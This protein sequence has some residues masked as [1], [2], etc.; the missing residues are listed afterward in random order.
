[1]SGGLVENRIH[2][3]QITLS[4][5]GP[6]GQPEVSA[7]APLPAGSYDLVPWASVAVLPSDVE[8]TTEELEDSFVEQRGTSATV[9]GEPVT[10]VVTGEADAETGRTRDEAGVVPA[11]AVPEP[12]C[13]QPAPTVAGAG[14]LQVEVVSD[15][16][17]TLG[18]RYDGP[19][20]ARG[21]LAAGAWQIAVRDGVV[22]GSNHIPIDMGAAVDLAYGP[23][24][25]VVDQDPFYSCAAGDYSTPLEAGEYLVYPALYVTVEDRVLPDGTV[26][27]G[28]GG[29]WV[30]GEPFFRT[31]P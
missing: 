8:L 22:V 30:I 21:W 17:L 29:T 31:L 28:E 12:T 11:V 16:P 25:D 15:D 13:G 14:D 6:E 27:P 3:D 18:L 23:S 20:R 1:M 7:G 9:R 5:C 24:I 10:V 26:L 2:G 4:V 19:G